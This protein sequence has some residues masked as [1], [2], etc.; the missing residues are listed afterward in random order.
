MNDQD[1]LADRFETHRAH[2]RGVAYRMLR[3]LTEADDAVQKAWIR[4]SRIDTRDVE[5]LRA[6]L[7]RVVARGCLNMLRSRRVR[8]ES[9]LVQ[10][11]A[12]LGSASLVRTEFPASSRS[13]GP[14]VLPLVGRPSLKR[15]ASSEPLVA[16]PA[17]YA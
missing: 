5:N 9:P 14:Y 6:W 2:L 10:P 4:L 13:V 12:P 3:S 1:R 15:V 8:L 16:S 17:L 11:V 7:T